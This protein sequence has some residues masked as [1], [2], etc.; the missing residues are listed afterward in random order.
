MFYI[1]LQVL[2]RGQPHDS[3][4]TF[5]EPHSKNFRVVLDH[6]LDACLVVHVLD[7]FLGGFVSHNIRLGLVSLFCIILL[8]WL[9]GRVALITIHFYFFLVTRIMPV[10][11]NRCKI[12]KSYI[13]RGT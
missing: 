9:I 8:S 5:R 13:L 2:F 11:C 3:C 6:G 7:E 4:C 10:C 1:Y 12:T